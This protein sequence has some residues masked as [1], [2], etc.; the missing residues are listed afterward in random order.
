MN[1]GD[2]G[3]MVAGCR[4]APVSNERCNAREKTKDTAAADSSSCTPPWCTGTMSV[5]RVAR[6][7]GSP[8]LAAP[9]PF[10]LWV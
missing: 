10:A 9:P 2:K 8:T 1:L 5:P 4:V 3:G 7:A 6:S